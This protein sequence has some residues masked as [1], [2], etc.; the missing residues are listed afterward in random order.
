MNTAACP[1][2]L[3]LTGTLSES[4][5]ARHHIEGRLAQYICDKD[6][7][8]EMLNRYPQCEKHNVPGEN[9]NINFIIIII[10]INSRWFSWFS[11]RFMGQ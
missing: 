5:R 6:Q 1:N 7:L 11:K 3:G 9:K 8:K 2:T 10:I 4:Q